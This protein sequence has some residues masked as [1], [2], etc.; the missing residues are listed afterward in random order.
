MALVAFLLCLAFPVL[1]ALAA[2]GDVARYRIPNS[3]SIALAA[4]YLPAALA[5]GAGL[6]EIAWHLAA[7]VGLLAIG[8][9]LFF[10]G[11][12]GGGDAKLI[13]AA[14]CWTGFPVLPAFLIYVALAGGALALALLVL[15]RLLVRVFGITADSDRRLGRLVARPRD[16]PYGLAIAIGGIAIFARLDAVR[17]AIGMH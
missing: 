12:L 2:W 14:A 7:G 11:V 6:S 5:A 8:I 1:L 10:A 4:S 3:L 16:V 13:A 15:R 9:A 17:S